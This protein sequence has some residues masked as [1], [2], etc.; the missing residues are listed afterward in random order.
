MTRPRRSWTWRS[1]AQAAADVASGEV[2][3]HH[4]FELKRESYGT[5]ES[6]KR[7]LAKDV[8]AL[9]VDGGTLVIG[10][11]E[12]RD[13]GR[14]AGLTPVD[15][16]GQVE[17]IRQVCQNRI[18]PPLAF[19]A[20][21]LV[22]PDDPSTGLIIIDVPPSPFAPHQVD[23]RYYGRADRTVRTLSDPEVIR[24]HRLR[25]ASEDSILD[26]LERARRRAAALGLGPSTLTVA[27]APIP[28]IRP[29]LLRDEL[30]D[31]NKWLGAVTDAAQ[32]RV[33][34]IDGD[35][36]L[37]SLVMQNASFP[38]T[39]RNGYDTPSGYAFRYNSREDTYAVLEVA[40][41][42]AVAL[43]VRDVTDAASLGRD[44]PE[45]EK[46]INQYE[47]ATFTALALAVFA[48]VAE[49]SGF[50]GVV[51][52]GLRLDGMRTVTPM[53]EQSRRGWDRPVPYPEDHYQ[54]VTSATSVELS[55]DL[56]DV[57]DRLYARLLRP[58]GL[59]DMLRQR[60]R[61]S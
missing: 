1:W 44:R 23:G 51:G 16:A 24:L 9:A 12:N 3:E 25:E 57:M 5:A 54:Q 58:L 28:V 21:D 55:G 46:V 8:A 40:Q 19:T 37:A 38:F 6:A 49:R 10:V 34:R 22:N 59:G 26:D 48:E 30:A 56:T 43:T 14:A 41:S 36:P 61:E 27:I 18:D 45:Y 42:G 13:S 2:H 20:T 60:P 15:L 47:A 7:E 29:E 32:D 53:R 33:R 35:S 11:E 17:R 39:S 52:V 4:Q 50:R 31:G